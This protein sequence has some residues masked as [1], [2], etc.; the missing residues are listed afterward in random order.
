M[1]KEDLALAAIH[2]SSLEG[3]L[4]RTLGLAVEGQGVDCHQNIHFLSCLSIHVSEQFSNVG[5][6]VVAPGAVLQR[7][8][9]ASRNGPREMHAESTFRRQMIQISCS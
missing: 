8:D 5:L 9:N 3:C 2:L 7:N 4:G 1:G 6:F